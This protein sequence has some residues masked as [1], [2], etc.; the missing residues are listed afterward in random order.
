MKKSKV[1]LIAVAAVLIVAML[2]IAAVAA[3]SSEKVTAILSAIV[4]G[5][6][7]L[8]AN[9]MNG[10]GKVDVL[11]AILAA[12]HEFFGSPT[13]K[14]L[15]L[16]DEDYT[17]EFDPLTVSYTVNLPAGR[18]R[19]PKLVATADDGLTI[20]YA[21]ATIADTE[22]EGSA[23]VTVRDGGK[24][25][26]YTVKFV[27]ADVE[28]TVVLQYD[29]R[30]TFAPDYTLGEG[31][32]FTFESSDSAVVS[33][34][35]NGVLTAEN[36][37]DTAVT[38]T[39][40]VGGEVKD[41]LTVAEVHKAQI[42]L[43][44]VTGQSNA[45]GCY[46]Y[47]DTDGSGAVSNYEKATQSDKQLEDVVQP[48]KAG[49]VYIYDA[50]PFWSSYNTPHNIAQYQW[51]DSLS[52][53]YD[54]NEVKRAGF[55]S[56]LGKTYYDLSGEKVVFLH[57]AYNGSCIEKWL[58]PVDYPDL[59]EAD[60]TS[61]ANYNYYVSTQ[62]AYSKLMALLDGN[63][64]EINHRA[65][66]W[67]QG[68]TCM[69]KV[70]DYDANNWA[71]PS[72]YEKLFS[73]EDYTDMFMKFHNQMVEDFGIESNNILLVRAH[74]S[75][76]SNK[77]TNVKAALNN[78]RSSQYGMAN[79]YADIN[80]VSRFSDYTVIQNSKYVGTIYE[81]YI[82]T[83]GVGNVHYNQTGHNINGFWAATNY[84]KKLDVETNSVAMSVELIDTDGIKRFAEKENIG[85]F[86]VG[87]TKRIAAFALPDYSLENVSY[88]SSNE[89]VA[90]VNEY[91]LI[92]V[93][94]EGEATITA[95]AESGVKA[96]V[97]VKGTA[98][99]ANTAVYTISVEQSLCISD[100]LSEFRFEDITFKSSDESVATVSKLGRVL[101][102]KEGTAVI[103][104]TS[105]TGA[106]ETVNVKVD[107]RIES[108]SVHY[109]W[110]FNGDLTSS[111][112]FNDLTVSEIST[113]NNAQGNYS[114]KDNCLVIP[115]SSPNTSRPEFSMTYPVTI[116]N[117]R[118]WSIEWKA[119]FYGGSLI[120]GQ[121]S[122]SSNVLYNAYGT[123]FGNGEKYPIR[124]V[125]AEG[126]SRYVL[127]GDYKK[128][129]TNGLNAWKLSYTAK[130]QTMSYY[131]YLEEDWQLVGSTVC[132]P[133]TAKF[134]NVGGRYNA[135]GLVNFRGEWDYLDIK[136][137]P[138]VVD[139][140]DITY[141]W[142]F[143]EGS[144]L[145]SSED[146]ND[147]SLTLASD[148]D[149]AT[150]QFVDGKIVST[151]SDQLKRPNYNMEIPVVLT[152]DFD[153]SIEWKAQF[154]GGSVLLGWDTEST[155]RHCLYAA[156]TTEA[157]GYECG[158]KLDDD[159]GHTLTLPYAET[160]TEAVKLNENAMN[161]W[162]L[163][164]DS[165]TNTLSLMMCPENSTTW[166]TIRSMNPKVS[167]FEQV[168]F[169]TLFGRFNE[170]GMVNF[171][172][173][174]DYMEIKTKKPVYEIV[175]NWDFSSWDSTAV[176]N[177]LIPGETSGTLSGGKYTAGYQKDELVLQKPITLDSNMDWSIEW[178][179]TTNT[180]N[181]L[182][183]TENS[184]LTGTKNNIY[185]AFTTKFSDTIR[186]PFRFT[187]SEG[188]NIDLMYVREMM[189]NGATED[190]LIAA[191]NA[192]SGKDLI[193][194]VEYKQ[195][196]G[197]MT[198]SRYEN[199]QW[200]LYDTVTTGAFS[201]TFTR[202]FG[203]FGKKNGESYNFVNFNGTADYMIV[204]YTT[205]EAN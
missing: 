143:N 66:F 171:R 51:N 13:L 163:N 105:V 24:S 136:V 108:N 196:T 110:D 200:V 38:V 199:G 2:A 76:V 94:G 96:S 187:T 99:S 14:T 179:A 97:T 88:S 120:L 42:N 186:Y 27:R 32:A 154:T 11:D 161:S 5:D 44:F 4:G 204:R 49:Q 148:R 41:T 198:L 35:E 77:D 139:Y 59:A 135:D 172:G 25:T 162:R 174:M 151:N 40:K 181:S 197:A 6:E 195:S 81:P 46:D 36:V 184:S 114:F 157:A 192:L 23:T 64:Y 106:Y 159:F 91:G 43:F 191:K 29:D 30:W 45:H 58:D 137:G 134:T 10:D 185:A 160:K 205:T 119:K 21:Q 100:R 190:E 147:L 153:W 118:D 12:K 116:D 83:M 111:A 113:N 61:T 142:D 178:R 168:T 73:S 152:R 180:S 98:R 169:K 122:S 63:N 52:R 193:W 17:L 18:P 133:F 104:A 7:Y 86:E 8:E 50:Q 20:D 167:Q 166:T 158:L 128:Y 141:R 15:K 138:A 47:S 176:P 175:Y 145:T 126:G 155:Y 101:G 144:E 112:D 33:V 164:Y 156:Y 60:F 150:A 55:A 80:I 1:V 93:V 3:L 170:A 85:E 140:E 26:V 79:S 82:G 22:T 183:G 130:N 129:N 70:W 95:T 65:N 182:F 84:F 54:L 69:S 203:D 189:N 28:D 75:V 87:T 68:E 201:A 74:G 72:I 173:T 57:S 90:N 124:L 132:D 67:L 127:Y 103:T 31:E 177:T 9:D 131:I 123:D 202:M 125:P 56:A 48:E 34:D 19:I 16:D 92:T 37:S 188:K 39:A 107:P 89:K 109:R 146:K 62:N 149:N 194:K 78:V 165:A 102:V 117:N 121:A 53:F 115:N 71:D